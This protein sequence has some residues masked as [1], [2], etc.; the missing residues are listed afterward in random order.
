VGHIPAS[1]LIATHLPTVAKSD[2]KSDA[3]GLKTAAPKAPEA[4]LEAVLDDDDDDLDALTS[5]LGGLGLAKK[6]CCVCQVSFDEIRQA[7]GNLR[8]CVSCD[9]DIKMF[10]GLTFST[11]IKQLMD[12]IKQIKSQDPKRKIIVFSQFVTFL[13]LLKPFMQKAGVKFVV[14][15][16]LVCIRW[17]ASS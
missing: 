5:A 8:F 7:K 17:R 10:E 13:N 14:C 4:K 2:E 12:T 9:G 11:K 15:E 6:R 16:C 3:E 1:V